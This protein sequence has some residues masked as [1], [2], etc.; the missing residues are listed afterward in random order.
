MKRIFIFACALLLSFAAVSCGSTSSVPEEPK[1]GLAA[2]GNDVN[3]EDSAEI[4]EETVQFLTAAALNSRQE[5]EVLI[6]SGVD[7]N[8]RGKNGWTALM[9]AAQYG[10]SD[11]IQALIEAGADVNARNSFGSSA[12]FIA[13][14]YGRSEIEQ[15]LLEAG[16][17]P[18]YTGD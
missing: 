10:A 7:V 4:S 11:A 8:A 13:K 12:V 9:L 14:N 2:G 17:Q 3:A 1:N 15:L 6:E 16:A 18:E 5:I